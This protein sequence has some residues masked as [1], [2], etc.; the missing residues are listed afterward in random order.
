[1][2]LLVTGIS[3]VGAAVT[4]SWP[5][6]GGI[7]TSGGAEMLPPCMGST[8]PS[9]SPPVTVVAPE[10]VGLTKPNGPS[11]A[12]PLS[13]ATVHRLAEQPVRCAGHSEHGVPAAYGFSP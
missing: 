10:A 4:T 12:V 3:A 8:G 7:A 9:S 1:M 6:G 11:V 2:Y 13:P 5:D